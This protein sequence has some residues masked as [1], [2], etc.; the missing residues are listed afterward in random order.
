MYAR[1]LALIHDK[2]FGHY[3]R[4]A[5]KDILPVIKKYVRRGE[6]V[7]ELGC[8]SGIFSKILFNARYKV[9]GIDISRV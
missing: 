8:G 7:L 5:A 2:Y 3:A 6:T 1:E 4:R 9:T